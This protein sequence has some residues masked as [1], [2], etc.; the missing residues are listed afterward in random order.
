MDN[1]SSEQIKIILDYLKNKNFSDLET[2]LSNLQ[3]YKKN[4]WDSIKQQLEKNEYN[5]KQKKAIAKLLYFLFNIKNIKLKDVQFEFTDN[6]MSSI[7]S[8]YFYKIYHGQNINQIKNINKRISPIIKEIIISDV[9][10]NKNFNIKLENKIKIEKRK[11]MN[12]ILRFIYEFMGLSESIQSSA[13]SNGASNGA[14]NSASNSRQQPS[15][16]SNSIL[17]EFILDLKIGHIGHIIKK[18]I[19]SNIFSKL[20]SNKSSYS[21]SLPI[22]LSALFNYIMPYIDND[23]VKEILY[24]IVYFFVNQNMEIPKNILDNF[25]NTN[26]EKYKDAELFKILFDNLPEFSKNKKLEKLFYLLSTQIYV[27]KKNQNYLKTNRALPN[28]NSSKYN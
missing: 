4:Y 18:M 16:A 15:V 14:S 10:L 8:P 7:I 6:K 23:I 22:F 25:R 17:K 3:S 1:N 13:A 24:C 2:F 20:F 21:Y 12:I 27:I 11:G 5:D 26:L 28:N 19:E 9:S